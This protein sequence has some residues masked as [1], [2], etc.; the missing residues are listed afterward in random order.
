[1]EKFMQKL[2]AFWSAQSSTG[3]GVIAAL[4]LVA[5]TFIGLLA[6]PD[7]NFLKASLLGESQP[8]P[9]DGTVYPVQE[10][11]N[12][13]KMT[14]EEY[15]GFRDGSYTYEVGKAAGKVMDVPRYDTQLLLNDP[16]S[17]SWSGA[18]LDIRNTLLTYVTA[19]M[20]AYT[21]GA[22]AA[23][24]Y[25]GSHLAVDIRAPRGTP[26][27]AIANGKVT[28]AKT[29]TSNGNVVVI[30]HP[31]VPSL[32]D[33]DA[34]TTYYSSYLHLDSYSVRDGQ[35]V[36]KGD[37][38]GTVGTTGIST[39]HHLHFQVDRDTAPWHP[40]W[41]FTWSEVSALGLDFF[42]GVNE[43][44]GQDKAI[45]N[46]IHPYQWI[47]ANEETVRVASSEEEV[48]EVTEEEVTEEE[49]VETET[50]EES[51]TSES[52]AVALSITASEKTLIDGQTA[53]LRLEVL[54]KDGE[55]VQDYSGE[56]TVTASPEAMGTL[57]SSL[58]SVEN[59]EAMISYTAG[60]R[61]VVTLSMS[62][63]DISG[64]VKIT[65]TDV[66]GE[67]ES[68]RLD[69]DTEVKLGEEVEVIITALDENG[70]KTPAPVE[71]GVLIKAEGVEGE[72]SKGLLSFGDFIAGQATIT[73]TPGEAGSVTLLADGG[74]IKGSGAVMTVSEEKV[75]PFTDVPSEHPNYTALMY[76]K[77][78]GVIAGYNDGSFKPD[79][80]VNRAEAT[81]IILGGS[82]IDA[83]TP[84]VS[85]EF[86]DVELDQWY[87]GWVE[88]ARELG[89]VSGNPDGTF[90]PRSSLNGA[91]ALKIILLTNDVDLSTT[92]VLRDPYEDVFADQWF[93]LYYQYAKEKF[94]VEADR[95]NKVYPS[96]DMT[97]GEL[98]EV[99]YR[100]MRM[101]ETG[102]ESY[103]HDL[104][105]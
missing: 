20:G 1:M 102:E 79:A 10:T 50:E 103:S 63:G 89:I 76:L 45:A 62:D 22:E 105:E 60:E 43:G 3:K 58:V 84:V 15:T 104:D 44:V 52:T 7:G 46:T 39:T 29:D 82:G 61:E 21:G 25:E 51:E 13:M 74:D 2:E 65:V 4:A 75:S 90:T 5:F 16:S 93:A 9:F 66:I 55:L 19:Y 100:L 32:E 27:Y 57:S 68:F 38:I 64:S 70:L 98:A 87:A 81:K 18:D 85:S 69:Y 24:E 71:G 88:R 12:W 42:S 30:K 26:V 17:L 34:T 97:R 59:G 53:A 80:K 56:F 8:D 33:P 35:I 40:Y 31:N 96:S 36:Q 67:V 72:T 94:L 11:L 91:E 54:D 83:L 86:P 73:F 77:Q 78:K 95:D 49:V 28:K 37:Q 48:V 23:H 14:S 99:M 101:V 92:T 6:S 41:P 47:H